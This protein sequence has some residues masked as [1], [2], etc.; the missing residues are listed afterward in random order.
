MKS[1]AIEN[2][3]DLKCLEPEW[4]DLLI[5]SDANTIFL[6]WEWISSWAEIHNKSKPYIIVVRDAADKLVGLAPLYYCRMKLLKIIS[7]KCLCVIGDVESGSD[8]LDF[9][10]SQHESKEI[11]DKI[12]MHLK[13]N[14]RN[15]DLL[16]MPRMSGWNK[17]VETICGVCEDIDIG[18]MKRAIDFSSV[19]LSGSFENYIAGFSRKH[20]EQ[21][22]RQERKVLRQNITIT[23]CQTE[24]D[25]A[26]FQEDLFRLNHKR[27][28][29]LNDPGT[30]VRKPN[31]KYFYQSFIPK[32]FKKGWLRFYRLSD[33]DGV[34]AIQLGYIYN[35]VFHQIQEGFDP[36]FIKGAGNTLR[37]EVLR[38]C[39]DNNITEY[40]FLGGY[41]E[42]KRRWGAKLRKGFN[43]LIAS[44]HFIPKI[45]VK[46]GVWPTGRYISVTKL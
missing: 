38:K 14:Q 21:L 13:K 46:Y 39:I 22:R 25:V 28:M 44:N 6:T 36:E 43:I 34:K 15:W 10:I 26:L 37:L 1:Y 7:L 11:T 29:T 16:W 40:D 45:V 35:N 31:E 27:W 41:S 8:Y 30:F 4:N 2:W 20:R 24:N 12:L 19:S 33:P 5:N 18:Y 3:D 9:I 17:S 23:Y 42:H 32:A